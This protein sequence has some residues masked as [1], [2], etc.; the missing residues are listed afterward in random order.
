M[1]SSP[2]RRSQAG[3]T[4]VEVL[5]ALS[6]LAVL[7]LLLTGALRSAGQTET[8]VDQRLQ[9]ADELRVAQYFLRDVLRRA[10]VRPAAVGGAGAGTQPLF[11]AGPTELAWV[12]VLPGGYGIGGRHFLRLAIEP[13]GGASALVLRY[14]P[15]SD[16][17]AFP[18]WSQAHAQVIVPHADGLSLRY[19][20]DRADQWRDDWPARAGTAN[21]S[22]PG[23]V[24]LQLTSATAWPVLVVR[25]NALIASDPSA[26]GFV[27]G[28]GR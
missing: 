26:S 19:L 3:F 24:E 2:Q 27:S 18:D 20:D 7:M 28:R 8:R 4:L 23:A 25:M 16:L 22:L 11:A 21:W 12:G 10:S 13:A 14:L 6:L 9:Q 5:I 1:T 15:W 17:P